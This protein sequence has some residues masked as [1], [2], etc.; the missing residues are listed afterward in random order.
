MTQLEPVQPPLH[1]PKTLLAAGVAVSV[2][3]ELSGKVAVQVVGQSIPAGV[4]VTVPEPAPLTDTVSD[5]GGALELKVAVAEVVALIVKAQVV[6]VP[7]HAP[8]HPP[9][10]KPEAGVAVSVTCVFC[11]KVAVQVVG[12]LTPE[13]ALVT[14]PVLTAGPVNVS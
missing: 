6:A 11:A 5:P 4:L 12:Q 10:V 7:L 8:P 13:G 3:C 1:S 9:N 14:V 2:T